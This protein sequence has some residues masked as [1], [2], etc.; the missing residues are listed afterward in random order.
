MVNLK[1]ISVNDIM[2][3]SEEDGAPK[4]IGTYAMVLNYLKE[5]PEGVTAKMVAKSVGISDERAR[6]ILNELSLRRDIFKRSIPGIKENLYYPNGKLIHKYL[7]NS[8]DIGDQIFKISFH[9][10]WRGPRVQIQERK[11]T[12]LEGEKV[13]G[14]IFV[15]LENVMSLMDFLN[16]MMTKYNTYSKRKENEDV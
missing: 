14:S 2:G 4:V 12:L 15:D 9:E 1:D 8:K 6:V 13:E 11:Y 16:E 3:I 5:Y 10:G 7:Q